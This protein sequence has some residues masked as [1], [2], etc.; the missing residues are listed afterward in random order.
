[1]CYAA[2]MTECQYFR[3]PGEDLYRVVSSPHTVLSWIACKCVPRFVSAVSEE[4]C[5]LG[6]EWFVLFE[7]VALGSAPPTE[8]VYIGVAIR[9]KSRLDDFEKV[10]VCLRACLVFTTEQR[11]SFIDS[12]DAITRRQPERFVFQ[13]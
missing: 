10:L 6:V 5:R 11:S 3:E 9:S 12:V 1:M 13:S 4:A 2:S 7:D 8:F